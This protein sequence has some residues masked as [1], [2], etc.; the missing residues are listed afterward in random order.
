[1][2]AKTHVDVVPSITIWDKNSIIT[3]PNSS[4]VVFYPSLFLVGG[5]VS[6]TSLGRLSCIH[7]FSSELFCNINSST[8]TYITSILWYH[9]IS[10]NPQDLI[11]KPL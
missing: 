7:N 2:P 1:M 9:L 5:L 3:H 4:W 6:L 8:N 10:I 11:K